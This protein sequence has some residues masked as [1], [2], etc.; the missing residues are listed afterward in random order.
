[1]IKTFTQNDLIRY[2]YRETTEKETD[3]IR[4][5]LLADPELHEQFYEL[6]SATHELQRAEWQPSTST[7]V[8][9][10]NHVRSLSQEKTN[11]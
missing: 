11:R 3:E 8:N 10:L 2:L 5:A 4:Q 6:C 1:M 9:I 7:V